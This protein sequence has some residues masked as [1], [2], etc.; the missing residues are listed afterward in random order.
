MSCSNYVIYTYAVLTNTLHVHTVIHG[1]TFS[2]LAYVHLLSGVRVYTLG[3]VSK[4]L[5]QEPWWLE[6]CPAFFFE[7]S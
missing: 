7:I 1:N 6:R 3:F 2:T 4:Q 5:S